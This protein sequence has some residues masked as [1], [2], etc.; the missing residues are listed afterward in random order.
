MIK[1][2]LDTYIL[3][4]AFIKPGGTQHLILE[5]AA[6]REFYLI[7]SPA[8]LEELNRTLH[9]DRLRKKYKY[10]H[11]EVQIFEGMSFSPFR[12]RG[13]GAYHYRWFLTHWE[14]GLHRNRSR[15]S[16]SGER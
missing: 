2:V 13:R 9:Y 14:S 10:R 8:I 15:L 16:G 11:T 5:K 3:V 7:L 6:R 4:S 1:A 12:R